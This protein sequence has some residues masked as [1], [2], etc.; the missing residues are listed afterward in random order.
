MNNEQTLLADIRRETAESAFY[1]GRET[2]S[3]SVIDV[4]G[5]VPRERFVPEK[6]QDR[7]YDNGPLPIGSGQTISQP[8]IVALMTDLLEIGPHASILE[9]GTGSGYQTAVLSLLAERVYTV[10]L[11]RSLSLEA[12]T[13]FID[14]HY[15]NI[16]TRIGNGYLGWPEFAPYDGII[17]TAAAP[18][19]PD[20]LTRQLKRGGRLV[21]PV[22]MPYAH[23]EL[24]LVNKA[25]DGNIHKTK[26]LDV[27]FVPLIDSQAPH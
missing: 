9:I 1:T 26:V 27:A 10:E 15:S 4:I 25:L 18:Q 11:L 7:A 3:E 2:L 23:Q 12:E 21:I 5:R 20:A 6:W 13:R 24:I 17:V 14:L 22:G 16:H 8:F 19:I